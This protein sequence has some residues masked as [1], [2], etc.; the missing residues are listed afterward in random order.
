[1]RRPELIIATDERAF[2]AQA[3]AI[4]ARVVNQSIQARGIFSAALSGGSTPKPLYQ[5]LASSE[6][7]DDEAWKFIHLFWGDE[8]HVPEDHPDSN[9]RMVQEALLDRVPIQ[10]EHIHRVPTEMDVRLAAFAYEEHLRTFF[11]G[12]WPRFDLVLLGMGADGHTASL[13]PHSAGLNETFRWF[14]ANE[15]PETKTWRLT[16][17]RNAI[18][19]AR[20]ILVMVRGEDKA[21]TV[22]QALAGA[23]TPEE[24]P[25]QLISPDDGEM[26]WLLDQDAASLL[27]AKL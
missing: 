21:E 19:A 11:P 1:M 12:E 5:R 14:I 23:H 2:T 22:S 15:I 7:I 8:R 24:R 25:I 18:N 27:P 13:F 17:T 10:P 3:E 4:F 6:L 16:L 9:Y 26:I 20:I